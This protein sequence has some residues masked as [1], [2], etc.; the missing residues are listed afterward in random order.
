MDPNYAPV[1]G[2]DPMISGLQAVSAA[3]RGD[4]RLRLTTRLRRRRPGVSHGITQLWQL[5]FGGSAGPVGR[6][7][8]ADLALRHWSRS[9]E[10]ES[11]YSSPALA[12]ADREEAFRSKPG[13]TCQQGL[14]AMAEQRGRTTTVALVPGSYQAMGLFQRRRGRS[15]TSTRLSPTK[16]R[17]Q[18]ITPTTC[19]RLSSQ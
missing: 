8:G 16:V 19:T 3:R 11:W 4:R 17:L 1:I 12:W 5:P 9:E 2:K 14:A 15:S 10:A 13:G 7:C 18:G 6:T